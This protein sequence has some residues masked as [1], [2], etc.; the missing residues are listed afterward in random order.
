MWHK[1]HF[2]WFRLITQ[3]DNTIFD[4]VSHYR[5][6]SLFPNGR[7]ILLF[8]IDAFSFHL[9]SHAK[10]HSIG[11]TGASFL[12]KRLRRC[13][14]SARSFRFAQT[15]GAGNR[16]TFAQ[17]SRLTICRRHRSFVVSLFRN[18]FF[19][20]FISYVSLSFLHTQNRIWV[21]RMV[22]WHEEYFHNVKWCV[23]MASEHSSNAGK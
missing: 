6:A 21:E 20:Y 4:K 16:F 12:S 5:I 3:I 18:F 22:R 23:V 15:C 1:D 10:L 17:C 14:F 13:C 2:F 8:P 9:D 11:F 19:F 7:S